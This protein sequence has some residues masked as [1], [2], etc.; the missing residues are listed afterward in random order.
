MDQMLVRALIDLRDRTLQKSRIAFGNRVSALERGTDQGRN[1][2]EALVGQWMERF[3]MLEDAADEDIKSL[4]A[5]VAIA[6]Y[7]M[8]VKGIGPMLIAKAI[9][10]IDISRSD[11]VSALWR[12]SG[13]G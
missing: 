2:A 10:M 11:T 9:A 7:A 1:G 6:E 4:M 12:Y 8:A 13:Y 5:D 3:Q